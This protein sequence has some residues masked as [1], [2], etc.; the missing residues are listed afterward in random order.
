V[1]A[2]FGGETVEE[3]DPSLVHRNH[4]EYPV[5]LRT[6]MNWQKPGRFVPEHCGADETPDLGVRGVVSDAVE[7]KG[8]QNG[9]A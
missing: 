9:T 3:E 4:G 6:S 7:V 2:D 8:A 1:P 5:L